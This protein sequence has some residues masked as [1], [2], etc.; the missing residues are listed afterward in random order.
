MARV[1]ETRPAMIRQHC[2]RLLLALLCSS[3]L[4]TPALASERIS[5]YAAASLT[6]VLG[7]I[8]SRYETMSGGTV[9]T[10]FASS[11]TLAK[12][13]EAGAPADIY[14]SADRQWMDYLQARHKIDKRTRRDLLGNTLVLIAPAG[15]TQ[16]VRLE[17]GF[18]L[19]AA[20]SGRLCTGDTRSVPVGIYAR[21]A[22]TRL[23][24]WQGVEPRL[25][26]TDDVRTALAFVA[27]G[28]CPLGIVYATDAR[29]TDK[30]MVVADFPAGSHPPV[31]YPVALV[32]GA[33]P[34]AREFLNYLAS[35]DARAIF[36]RHGFAV[37]P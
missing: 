12:Q 37:L 34:A 3:L 35:A 6:N 19:A 4:V 18:D 1:T 7:D 17:K 21:E 8:V 33:S 29:S 2:A 32:A 30:V 13:I 20:F 31:V 11:S 28:E 9:K 36:I 27:R 23:G 25:V 5:V 26:A 16:E 15:R 24:M 14:V 10:S 22:L